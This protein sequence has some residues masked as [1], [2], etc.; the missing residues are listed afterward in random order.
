VS[1]MN[2]NQGY[3]RIDPEDL[4]ERVKEILCPTGQRYKLPKQL[5]MI[6]YLSDQSKREIIEKKE[7]WPYSKIGEYIH[8]EYLDVVAEGLLHKGKP[9]VYAEKK[10]RTNRTSIKRVTR[11]VNGKIFKDDKLWIQLFI[12]EEE[13]GLD[14]IDDPEQIYW[15]WKA[16]FEDKIRKEKKNEY[17]GNH[18][19]TKEIK[20]LRQ[21]ITNLN[22]RYLGLFEN[23]PENEEA[24][25]E[26][27]PLA[28]PSVSEKTF[29]DD[30][31]EQVEQR[32]RH[33]DV[34]Y[35]DMLLPL[36]DNALELKDTYIGLRATKDNSM[37][38]ATPLTKDMEMSSGVSEEIVEEKRIVR[39]LEDEIPQPVLVDQILR[40]ILKKEDTAERH[41]VFL[42]SPGSGKSTLLRY[43]ALFVASNQFEKLG[44]ESFAPIFIDLAE[45]ARSKE[46]DLI[47]FAL[48][49]AVENIVDGSTRKGIKEALR[50]C[51]NQCE[52]NGQTNGKV[53]FLMD[54][55]D[56]IRTEKRRI[57][58]QIEDIRNRYGKAFIIVTSR[59]K[60]Y[61]ESPFIGFR[62]YPIQKLQDEELLVFVRKWFELIAERNAVEKP[63]MDWKIWA[64]DRA[65]ILI[66]KIKKI[67]PLRYIA[68]TPLYLT[69]LA[70]LSSDPSTDIP[71]TRADLFHQFIEKLILK[72]EEKGEPAVAIYSDDLING[73]TEICWIIHG[74]LYGDIQYEPTL[75]FVKKRLVGPYS[76]NPSQILD[77]WIKA[78]VF[79]IVKTEYRKELILPAHSS[80]LEYGFAHKLTDLWDD[81]VEREELWNCL[82]LN[83]RNPALFEP[84]LLLSDMVKSPEDFLGR[85]WKCKDDIFHSN[86]AFVIQGLSETHEKTRKSELLTNVLS[87]VLNLWSS[88][89]PFFEFTKLEITDH[90]GFIGGAHYVGELLAFE[91][92]ISVRTRL[93]KAIG[94]HSS[95]S[96]LPILEKLYN[97]GRSRSEKELII[98]TIG[99]YIDRKAALTY[100]LRLCSLASR[101]YLWLPILEA[102]KALN[103]H[104]SI[105]KL[106]A[107]Y[108]EN[109]LL[110]TRRFIIHAIC[111][112]GGKTVI[113]I[114]DRLF[115]KDKRTNKNDIVEG[116]LKIENWSTIPII[117]K[118]QKC[119]K[120]LNGRWQIVTE[121]GNVRDNAAVSL[122]KRIYKH[123]LDTVDSSP[124]I[125]TIEEIG[126]QS[127]IQFLEQKYYQC[128]D[129]SDRERIIDA[130]TR[131]WGR[132]SNRAPL[133]SCSTVPKRSIKSEPS[134]LLSNIR[135]NQVITFL[136][137]FFDYEDYSVLKMHIVQLICKMGN[138]V[139]I[140]LVDELLE[141]LHDKVSEG[142]C[143]SEIIESICNF[144]D[145]KTISALE[146][147]YDNETES[148]VRMAIILCVCK[149]GNSRT[150]P[151]FEKKYNKETDT[152]VRKEIVKS[153]CS[154]GDANNINLLEKL[155]DKEVD[156]SVRKE[157]VESI[158]KKSGIENRSALKNRYEIESDSDVKIIIAKAIGQMGYQDFAASRLKVLFEMEIDSDKRFRIARTIGELGY[159]KLA[160]SYLKMLFS[161][162]LHQ[163]LRIARELERI[164]NKKIA[165]FC[166]YLI[167][168]KGRS[169]NKFYNVT[170]FIRKT[171]EKTGIWV[172]MR[173][174]N[175]FNSG[176]MKKDIAEA[177]KKSIAESLM[178]MAQT[179]RVQ[180]FEF[181]PGHWKI[182]K[183]PERYDFWK[184]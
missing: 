101:F 32:N 108:N 115:E 33:L 26:L 3:S 182:I 128:D 179:L 39:K 174:Y 151:L 34:R 94:R 129:R 106:E 58:R 122:L 142:W 4:F 70:L 54:A 146:K 121:S 59:T 180:I 172:L 74:S 147:L 45:Y 137:Q 85:I 183:T 111:S 112:I 173:L 22:D 149:L 7:I 35:F 176:S 82:K 157:I 96:S 135:D 40:G 127:T 44:M 89:N 143:R 178:V 148:G 107:L 57:V 150:I 25:S 120:L 78:G 95:N 160:T 138:D 109:P 92:K 164:G 31:L 90:L 50:H 152:S 46:G 72:W 103:D 28:S 10:A 75:S 27:A 53:L 41:I 136:R 144:G 161:R 116:I 145:A 30:Y 18:I 118:F 99:Q 79:H 16:H 163:R 166:F 36:I 117:L 154:L 139:T 5:L 65:N 169:P 156:T 56:E 80:F 162:N 29:L 66:D 87:Y 181:K 17:E 97:N 113:P 64:N 68:T 102:I 24:P 69:F 124:A 23:L 49:K 171:N 52:N 21:K 73:F 155:C 2:S 9:R 86:L 81:P 76:L 84:I 61:Y 67:P 141:G 42:G 62:L 184:E 19:E 175:N 153:I 177:T 14:L 38:S 13:K 20:I 11:K 77:F 126:D 88:Q 104:A 15:S 123:E 134:E 91:R 158:C 48:K 170:Q 105:P 131:I 119:D 93:I 8:A 167:C 47:T 63:G 133:V 51:I 6:E 1:E 98:S 12:K 114:L 71:Q 43:L 83:L 125:R 132:L 165:N 60:D 100:L 140:P 168:R 55:L 37:T 110:P 130:I 159:T